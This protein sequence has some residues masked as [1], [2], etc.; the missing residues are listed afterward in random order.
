MAFDHGQAG[1]C[2]SVSHRLCAGYSVLW[3]GISLPTPQMTVLSAQRGELGASCKLH[4]SC[5]GGQR[6]H[7]SGACTGCAV[8]AVC[9][10]GVS[11]GLQA[12][13]HHTGLSQQGICVRRCACNTSA[14]LQH[15]CFM[16]KAAR[17]DAFVLHF[18]L[19]IS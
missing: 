2:A 7:L 10:I 14:S 13:R 16:G 3:L 1:G 17:T 4:V 12:G 15:E 5:M 6:R 11:W 19:L 18:T 8:R 9:A